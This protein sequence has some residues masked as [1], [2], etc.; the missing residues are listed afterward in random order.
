MMYLENDLKINSEKIELAIGI[1]IILL[2]IYYIIK[3]IYFK[4]KKNKHTTTTKKRE[5]IYDI[6]DHFYLINN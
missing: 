2:I 3:N 5:E 1:V 4:N 6:F